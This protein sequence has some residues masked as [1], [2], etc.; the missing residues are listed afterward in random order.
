MR[1]ARGRETE[2]RPNEELY[3]AL[4]RAALYFRLSLST[5]ANAR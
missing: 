4:E 3:V 2:H 5:A 1:R